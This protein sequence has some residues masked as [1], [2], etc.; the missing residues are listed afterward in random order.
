MTF[1][2]D[3]FNES[4]SH[5]LLLLFLLKPEDGNIAELETPMIDEQYEHA[6]KHVDSIVNHPIHQKEDF[7]YSLFSKE[8]KSF[9]KFHCDPTKK[10]VLKKL[11]SRGVYRRMIDLLN[12]L[13]LQLDNKEG[14]YVNVVRSY[15]KRLQLLYRLSQIAKM[16]H[17]VSPTL[18]KVTR[19]SYMALSYYSGFLAKFTHEKRNFRILNRLDSYT[20]KTDPKIYEDA[21]NRYFE[22]SL[23]AY[24][25]DEAKSKEL[26]NFKLF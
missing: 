11:F 7:K 21:E 3:F 2:F 5:M 17:K 25:K 1:I 22:E 24:D 14:T 10:E 15:E 26:D 20:S 8:L 16:R 6:L 23:E 13:S 9:I 18:N 4:I 19:I 12:D